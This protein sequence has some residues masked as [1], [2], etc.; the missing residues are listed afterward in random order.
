MSFTPREILPGVFHIEDCM[1]VCMTLLAGGREALLVDTGYGL[2][3]VAAC[4]RSLT[5]KPVRVILTHG[6][7][8]HALGCRWFAQT[9]M[10]PEDAEVFRT[11]T[12][13]RWRDHVRGQAVA[14]GFSP[15]SVPDSDSLWPM[16][17]K[18]TAGSI[19]LGGLTAQVMLRPG[20]TPGSAVVY[21]PERELLLTGDD[22]NPCTWLF[23]REALPLRDY[24]AGMRELLALPFRQVLC[25]HR[26]ELYPRAW[27]EAFL[28]GITP[29]AMEAAEDS[30]EGEAQGIHTRTLKPAPEQW[31]VFDAD[32][33]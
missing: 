30:P 2:E 13:R 16:P 6:H 28:A 21:V 33:A 8:D 15:Q 20:H 31:I 9:W 26:A 24:L 18:L 25:S 17:G 7:H 10:F 32:K 29:E 22:W 12:G 5:D 4:V 11:Y 23:F 27:L 1:G 3:D 14:R 19:D